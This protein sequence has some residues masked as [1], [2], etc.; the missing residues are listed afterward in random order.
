MHMEKKKC[1]WET[2]IINRVLKGKLESWAKDDLDVVTD[3][4]LQPSL[5][6]YATIK[7]YR[8]KE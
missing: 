1:I 4:S 2:K 8:I 6:C 5:H 3:F 7:K